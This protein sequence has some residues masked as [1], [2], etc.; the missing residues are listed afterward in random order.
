MAS[1]NR[2]YPSILFFHQGS[3]AD[4]QA[5]FGTY[6]PEAR[7]VADPERRFYSA[8]G[9]S[10]GGIR[11]MFGPGVWA[12]GLRAMLKG[13]MGGAPVGD[14][15]AMPGLFLVRENAVLWEHRYRHA[16]DHPDFSRI[17]ERLSPGR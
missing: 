13:N 16:G 4:G 1:S 14:P 15:W 6:W 17:V 2:S 10:R 12:A 7:A 8:F 5:F 9:L 3:L 11:E